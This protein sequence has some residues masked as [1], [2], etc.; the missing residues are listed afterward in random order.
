MDRHSGIHPQDDQRTSKDETI[1]EGDL[2]VIGVQSRTV[3]RS[4]SDWSSGGN[5]DVEDVSG[6]PATKVK[7]VTSF[8][9]TN[10]DDLRSR[11]LGDRGRGRYRVSVH[12]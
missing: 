4:K 9:R 10:F 1:A 6:V 11:P 12:P 8:C 7:I 2:R 5:P 3:Q